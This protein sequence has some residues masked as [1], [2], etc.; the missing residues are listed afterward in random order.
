M[1]DCARILKT[2]YKGSL[3]TAV[4]RIGEVFKD[5][6]RQNTAALIDAHNHP[7]EDCSPSLEDL[8]VTREIVNAGRLSSIDVLDHVIIGNNRYTSLGER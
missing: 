7:S 8:R 4:V 2:V 3:N 1:R 6:I 5:V